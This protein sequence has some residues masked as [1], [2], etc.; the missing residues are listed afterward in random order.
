MTK[1]IYADSISKAK[2]YYE[3]YGDL[4]HDLTHTERVVKNAKE[5]ADS[6]E[7]KDLDFLELCVYW[8]DV[9][10]TQSK[11]PRDVQGRG[12]GCQR[13]GEG[14][15]ESRKA[16]SRQV[17]RISREAPAVQDALRA[18]PCHPTFKSSTSKHS[19]ELAGIT[20]GISREP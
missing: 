12:K 19:V 7:Y 13:K 2:G 14:R 15:K 20:P 8:H 17:I 11:E 4:L 5:I 6:L 9:A 16:E 3:E 10:R 18:K 1:Q